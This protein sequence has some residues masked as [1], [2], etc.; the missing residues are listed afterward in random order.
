M[1]FLKMLSIVK[2]WKEFSEELE[3]SSLDKKEI[4]E[5][6]ATGIAKPPHQSKNCSSNTLEQSQRLLACESQRL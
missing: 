5:G 4:I 3:G 2:Q 6:I 1:N